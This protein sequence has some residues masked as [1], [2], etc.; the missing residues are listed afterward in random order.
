MPELVDRNHARVQAALG[1]VDALDVQ[2]AAEH[3]VGVSRQHRRQQ[4]EPDVLPVD[5]VG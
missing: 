4:V 1:Q 3:R 5:V 2:K